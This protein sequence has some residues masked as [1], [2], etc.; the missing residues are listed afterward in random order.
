MKK[1]VTEYDAKIILQPQHVQIINSDDTV[2]FIQPKSIAVE[3]PD[4]KVIDLIEMIESFTG[5]EDAITGY[6]EST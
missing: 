5:G 6:S 1:Y 3:L 4:G 2:I